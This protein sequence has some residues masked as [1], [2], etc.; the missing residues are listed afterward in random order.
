LAGSL[1]L[2]ISLDYHERKYAEDSDLGHFKIL[3][4]AGVHRW[5]SLTVKTGTYSADN[6]NPLLGIFAGRVSSLRSLKILYDIHY[7]SLS[8]ASSRSTR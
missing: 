6:P 2:N 5:R 8:D 3:A 7:S 4:Q 1:H